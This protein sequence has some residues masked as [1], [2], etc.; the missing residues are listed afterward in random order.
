MDN[1]QS[2][3]GHSTKTNGIDKRTNEYK[4]VLNDAL[5]EDELI[6][7]VRMLYDKAIDKDTTAAKMLLETYLGKPRQMVLN[8]DAEKFI[9]IEPKSWV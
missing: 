3:G 1:R 4:E 8:Y 9:S 7:V 5:T 6:K 2:N